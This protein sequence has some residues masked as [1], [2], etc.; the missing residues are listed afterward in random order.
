MSTS[1]SYAIK[2]VSNM[3]AAVQFHLLNVGS[4]SGP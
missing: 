4:V 3:E 1:F 2:Y